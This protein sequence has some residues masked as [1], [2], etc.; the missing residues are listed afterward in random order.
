MLTSNRGTARLLLNINRRAKKRDPTQIRRHA[1]DARPDGAED[2]RH[3]RRGPR[4]RH[5]AADPAGI[6]EP[7]SAQPGDVVSRAAQARA[8]RVDLVEMGR[9]GEHPTGPVL[10]PDEE[11]A[12]AART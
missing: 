4:L 7:A 9:L 1:G 11:R 12:P 5:R 10:R 3:A 6:P 2:P 8:E